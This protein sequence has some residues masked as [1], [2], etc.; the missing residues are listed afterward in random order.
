MPYSQRRRQK[1]EQG[2]SMVTDG[3]VLIAKL[4]A[5]VTQNA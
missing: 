3:G 1:F 5:T 2:E 4:M